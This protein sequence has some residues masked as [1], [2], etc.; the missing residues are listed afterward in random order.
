MV[1]AIE[2]GVISIGLLLIYHRLGP[3]KFSVS[4]AMA[5]R[6]FSR[7]KYYILASLMVMAFQNTD[8]IMLKTMIGDVE[9]GFY[10]AAITSAGVIQF[11]YYAI[12]DSARPV[13]LTEKRN[14]QE[15]YERNMSRLY[16]VIVYLALAQSLVFSI[17]AEPIIGILYGADY[18]ASVPVLRILVWYLSFSYMGSIRNIWILAEGKHS[19]L[20]VINLCGV[21]ANVVLNACFI[22]LWGACG[23]AGASVLTQVFTNVVVGFILKDIRPNNRLMLTGLDP[24]FAW[25]TLRELLNSI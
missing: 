8:H 18:M 3:Q 12:I 4:F 11:A 9:N 5:K 15:R 13:I 22:P 6:L 17:L 21:L 23:A 19:R 20:W 2:F 1:S 16:C 7:S 14:S 10:T 25:N 24:K